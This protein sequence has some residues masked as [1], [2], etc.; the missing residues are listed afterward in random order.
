L[1]S[2]QSDGTKLKKISFSNLCS[3]ETTKNLSRPIYLEAPS[4]MTLEKHMATV[5]CRMVGLPTVQ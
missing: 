4:A 3:M 1:K 2:A 5:G